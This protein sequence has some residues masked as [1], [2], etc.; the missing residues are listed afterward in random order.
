MCI[1]FHSSS[2]APPSSK[3][4]LPHPSIVALCPQKP[5][6]A[7]PCDLTKGNVCLARLNEPGSKPA[8]GKDGAAGT[9][10]EA[11]GSYQILEAHDHPVTCLAFR[12]DGQWLA[13][14]SARGT[15]IRV[16]DTDTKQLVM[17]LKRSKIGREAKIH[18]LCFSDDGTMLVVSSSTPTIHIF[19]IQG[20][21]KNDRAFAFIR[22]DKQ[23]I[24]ERHHISSFKP[25]NQTVQVAFADGTFQC[26]QLPQPSSSSQNC[27][28]IDTQNLLERKKSA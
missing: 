24:S 16:W 4:I 26:Y 7:Y 27:T 9:D 25:D 6:L 28:L 3:E 20:E 17:E 19:A 5:I 1:C 2:D 23:K 21:K 13:T 18:S 11:Y 12:K 8:G 22:L 10:T 15:I 14:A